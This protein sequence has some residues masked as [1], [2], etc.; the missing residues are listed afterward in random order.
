MFAENFADYADAV[1]EEVR[2]A[3]PVVA[4]GTTAPAGSTRPDDAAEG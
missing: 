2:A 3:G 4:P 1:S